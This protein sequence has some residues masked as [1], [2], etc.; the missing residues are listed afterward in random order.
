MKKILGMPIALFVIGLIVVGGA[1]AAIVSYLSN[2]KTVSFESKSPLVMYFDG[3]A[4]T[5]TATLTLS[6]VRGGQPITYSIWTENK[7]SVAIDSYPATVITAPDGQVFEG[8]EFTAVYL[9]DPYRTHEDVFN[10]MYYRKGSELKL[11][12]QIK[13]NGDSANKVVLFFTEGAVFPKHTRAIGFKENNQLEIVL[14]PALASG[15]YTIESCQLYS[16]TGN[17]A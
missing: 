9:T 16:T 3:Q 8:N 12:S 4:E 10:N 6:N 1:S 7:A 17:C 11:F 14:N 15:T 5:E 13:T 2:T